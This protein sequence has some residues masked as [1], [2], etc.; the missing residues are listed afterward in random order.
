MAQSGAENTA[1]KVAAVPGSDSQEESA[2]PTLVLFFLEIKNVCEVSLQ[3]V[4]R[5]LEHSLLRTGSYV[6]FALSSLLCIHTQKTAR[7]CPMFSRHGVEREA[8][9]GR[10]PAGF[11]PLGISSQ[12]PR[13]ASLSGH[14]GR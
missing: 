3:Q 1:L 9:G 14:S 10:N 11:C 4:D 7:Q 8:H 13:V 2:S 5:S 12:D 6:Q